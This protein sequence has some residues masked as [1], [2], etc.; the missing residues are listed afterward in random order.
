MCLIFHLINSFFIHVFFLGLV[1]VDDEIAFL[2]GIDLCYGRYDDS[3]YRLTDPE[4]KIFP[5]RYVTSFPLLSTLFMPF[6]IIQHLFQ[7]FQH[8]SFGIECCERIYFVRDYS[9]LYLGEK[10]GPTKEEVLDRFSFPFLSFLFLSFPNLIL[11]FFILFICFIKWQL[12]KY[13]YYAQN[14]TMETSL[15]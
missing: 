6:I 1:V 4:G 11:S 7:H 8:I 9:H 15:A 10:N 2:G 12:T 5:G 14:K 13:L 3:N